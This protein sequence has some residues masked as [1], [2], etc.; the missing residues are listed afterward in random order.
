MKIY[1]LP[2]FQLQ[3]DLRIPVTAP[4]PDLAAKDLCEKGKKSRKEDWGL[5]NLG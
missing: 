5:G 1:D 3:V 4:L 2:I